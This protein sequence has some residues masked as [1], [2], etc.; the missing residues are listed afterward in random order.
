MCYFSS[1][2]VLLVIFLQA[3]FSEA[4]DSN[5]YHVYWSTTPK[6]SVELLACGVDT[7]KGYVTTEQIFNLSHRNDRSCDLLFRPRKD[8]KDM[9]EKELHPI[10]KNIEAAPPALKKVFQDTVR[11][12]FSKITFYVFEDG[13]IYSKGVQRSSAMTIK[14][15]RK[16][17][18]RYIVLLNA[19]YLQNPNM[20]HWHSNIRNFN[21]GV[22]LEP[23]LLHEILRPFIKNEHDY[24]WSLA[25]K[26][27]KYTFTKD[28]TD[29]RKLIFFKNV[30]KKTKDFYD[31]SGEQ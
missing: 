19:F 23:F 15:P 7:S 3:L 18:D 16:E 20:L 2:I 10:Y 5:S 25:F 26:S 24:F 14:D 11:K 12:V 30:F 8:Y 13:H 1:Y 6:R 27:Y 9:L 29:Q 21:K 31:Q 4:R 22:Y 17:G 28:K